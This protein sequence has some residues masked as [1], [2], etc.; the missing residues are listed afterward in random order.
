MI[1]D[2]RPLRQMGAVFERLNVVLASHMRKDDRY[3]RSQSSV[4]SVHAK[5]MSM[6]PSNTKE[7]L[8]RS[9]I[10]ALQRG[11]SLSRSDISPD[12]PSQTGVKSPPP[13]TAEPGDKANGGTD[14]S[15]V[16]SHL[17]ADGFV[18]ITQRDMFEYVFSTIE[19]EK[20]V[21]SK[22]LIAVLTEYIRTLNYSLI[23][24]EPFLYSKLIEVL[25]KA[26]RFQQ[27]C[28][29]IQYHVIG[30][31]VPVAFQLVSLEPKYPP[32]Y[33]M[34]LDMLKRLGEDNIILEVLL[35]KK[36]L[37][38][39]LRFTRSMKNKRTPDPH[40]FLQS[41]IESGNRALFYTVYNF[42]KSK[43]SIPK[44]FSLEDAERILNPDARPA[45]TD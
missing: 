19:E 26:G 1:L 41:A 30:D 38:Q 6:L 11:D 34:A 33:Q 8:T 25:V 4:A 21:P 10:P 3:L 12:K 39:A 24:V 42:F 17:N 14:L 18:V 40:L 29:F 5:S 32:A 35:A 27:L 36:Q 20:D 16:E 31:S 43:E 7:L 9:A 44:D 37:V 15:N 45:A 13:T 2:T 22:Y 28:Q 23:A